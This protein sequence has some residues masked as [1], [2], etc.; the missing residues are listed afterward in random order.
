MRYL[1][2]LILLPLVGCFSDKKPEFDIQEYHTQQQLD[3]A[4]QMAEVQKDLAIKE[5]ILGQYSVFGMAMFAVG[6]LI[7]AFSPFHR[8]GGFVFI[9]GGAVS[10]ASLW[11]FDSEW[12]PWVAGTTAVIAVGLMVY[13]SI[14][15]SSPDKQCE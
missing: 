15:S 2:L 3:F 5:H 1:T 10:M 12:F 8:T 6:C 14:K 7:L 4:I 11:L 13:A 9:A